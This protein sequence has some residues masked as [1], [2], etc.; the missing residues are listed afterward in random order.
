MEHG[1]N[2]KRLEKPDFLLECVLNLLLSVKSAF[3][4]FH[5]F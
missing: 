5:C 1:S 3:P 2:L 4:V